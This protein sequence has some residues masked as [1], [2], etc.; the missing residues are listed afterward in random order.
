MSIYKQKTGGLILLLLFGLLGANAQ[1]GFYDL[2]TLPLNNLEGF[3]TPNANWQ[4]VGETS[5]SPDAK[6]LNSKAGT[7]VL[8]DNFGEK[9]LYKRESDLYSALE[10]GDMYLELDFML[11]QGSNSGIYLQSRYE[12]QLF[13]SWGTSHPKYQDNGAIYPRWIE[14]TKTN[15]EGHAPRVNASM[16]PGLW[17]HLQ[18]QF[19]APQFDAQGRKIKPAVFS[20]IVLNGVTIHENVVL[21]GVT[22]GA[23]SDTEVAKAPFRI[24]G[25]HGPVAFRNIKYALLNEF[26]APLKA[27]TYQY[28]EGNFENFEALATAKLTREGKADRIDYTLADN[29][30]K[31]G[32]VFNGKIEIKEAA[33]YQWILQRYGTAKLSVDG[34]EVLPSDWKWVGDPSIATTYL[35]AGE[36]TFTVSYL[37][38]FSWWPTAAGLSLQKTNGKPIALHTRSSLPD[39]TPTPLISLEPTQEPKLLRCFYQHFK[40]KKTHVIMVGDPKGIHYAYDLNQGALLQAWRGEFANVTEMWYERGEPQTAAAMGAGVLFTGRCP[41]AIDG[42]LDTL[43]QQ[44]ELL[45]KG[46]QLSADRYPIFKYQYN[47]LDFSESFRPSANAQALER[48]TTI[49]NPAGKKFSYRVVQG[50][51]ISSLGNGL[52][53]VDGQS[54]YVRVADPAGFKVVANRG[55]KEL[56]LESAQTELKVSSSLIF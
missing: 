30:N 19:Q 6:T 37:K 3:R 49:K 44:K 18:I 36:H 41:L 34:K 43:D 13:D 12:V 54:Y 40:K 50:N 10:H 56:I 11:P 31:M 23:V 42:L 2:S 52:Y 22:R 26:E 7:G 38:N 4:I 29:V 33:N 8:F 16:A 21:Q 17:Q 5:G 20:K 28:Y 46:Y 35:S 25:D 27:L 1:S 51:E 55:Q 45:Y 53:A 15:Y 32:L 9:F 14:A 39:P 47:G 48:V 24:Q